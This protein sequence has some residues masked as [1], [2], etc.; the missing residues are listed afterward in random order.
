MGRR[1][2]LWPFLLMVAG[3]CSSSSPTAPSGGFTTPGISL[4][5]G[6]EAQV[7][8]IMNQL[9]SSGTTCGP[10]TLPPAAPLTMN[11]D[12]QE[13]ARAH[14]IDMVEPPLFLSHHP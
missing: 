14:S 1:P 7:V 12:L 8:T 2:R 10:T 13:A 11:A 4:S 9:R 5:P 6:F 3:A